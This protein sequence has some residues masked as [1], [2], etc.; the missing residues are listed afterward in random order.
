MASRGR[1]SRA[2]LT[3][4]APTATAPATSP[5][6]LLS[7]A[8]APQ[9]GLYL[10]A[11]GYAVVYGV[12][13]AVYRRVLGDVSDDSGSAPCSIF[14]ELPARDVLLDGLFHQ[15]LVR[16]REPMESDANWRPACY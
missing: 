15:L 13:L 7:T 9:R 8:A 12:S 14:L 16:H 5:A 2:T 10:A 3:S 6:S 1:T 4:S 11:L